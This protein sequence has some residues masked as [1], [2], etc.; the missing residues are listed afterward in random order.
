MT[1]QTLP[2]SDRNV[3]QFE[4]SSAPIDFEAA[5]AQPDSSILTVGTSPV[6]DVRADPTV[7]ARDYS[8]PINRRHDIKGDDR[9]SFR[10]HS[11]ELYA[12]SRE[13]K[14]KSDDG[15]DVNEQA[16]LIVQIEQSLERLMTVKFGKSECLQRCV[17]AIQNVILQIVWEPQHAD[18]IESV[19]GFLQARSH[20]DDSTVDHIYQIIK[21]FGLDPFRGILTN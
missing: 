8:P 1:P 9:Q 20:I 16:D 4:R 19:A 6:A 21:E 14:R 11:L 13:L 17:V 12:S 2:T 15:M 18:F 3:R 7:R 5:A 10:R